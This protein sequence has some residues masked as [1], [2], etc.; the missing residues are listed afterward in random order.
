[1]MYLNHADIER[2]AAAV[3]RG[4]TG[5]IGNY[6]L[7]SIDADALARSMG[8]RVCHTCLSD[9][10][11]IV[12]VTTYVDT[13]I[14]LRRH[15]RWE[16]LYVPRNI[17]LLDESLYSLYAVPGRRRYTLAHECAHHILWRDAA[18]HGRQSTATHSMR[19]SSGYSRTEWQA[20]ALAAAILM[21]P[22]LVARHM[23]DCSGRDR[24]VVSYDGHFTIP[25]KQV[26]TYLSTSLGVSWSALIIRLRQL[27][28][29]SDMPATAYS[30]PTEV[31]CDD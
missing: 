13:V 3:V 30:D 22:G 25:D 15:S 8:L 11:D 10:G 7:P 4:F 6:R 29:L 16:R 12:G 17:V 21:P 1:M 5:G 2:R 27:G 20:N 23:R 26:L 9:T 18:T 24:R 28:Y 31:W 19:S 14:E